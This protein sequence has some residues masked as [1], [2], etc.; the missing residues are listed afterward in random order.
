MQRLVVGMRLKP[1]GREMK[2]RE[3]GVERWRQRQRER[4][5]EKRERQRETEREKDGEG[6]SLS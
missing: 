6:A 5:T 1:E 2:I 3:M 4:H